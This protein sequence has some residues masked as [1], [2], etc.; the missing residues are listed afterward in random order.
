MLFQIEL[1]NSPGG[2]DVLSGF[3]EPEYPSAETTILLPYTL[4]FLFESALGCRGRDDVLFL[5]FVILTDDDR[6]LS[7]IS[8]KPFNDRIAH[9]HRV[10]VCGTR[11]YS[12]S[13]TDGRNFAPPFTAIGPKYFT[14]GIE[15]PGP[16]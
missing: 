3:V 14:F 7:I 13:C 6:V 12:T 10:D 15:R 9:L 5:L 8:H 16:V 1:R 11:G 2:I 4:V